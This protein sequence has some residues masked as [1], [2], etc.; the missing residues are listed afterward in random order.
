MCSE[1]VS[2]IWCCFYCRIHESRN[3]GSRNWSVPFTIVSSDPLAKFLLPVTVSLCLADL[4]VLVLEGG[5]FPP[6]R[7]NNYS[8]GLEVNIAAWPLRASHASET[9]GNKRAMVL[10]G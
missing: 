9:A 1:S 5:M 8:I 3:H 7:H 10:A 6:K 4:E 2:N